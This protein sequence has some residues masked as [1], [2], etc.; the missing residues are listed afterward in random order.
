M[1]IEAAKVVRRLVDGSRVSAMSPRLPVDYVQTY[2]ASDGTP[3]TV[4][5]AMVFDTYESGLAWLAGY[6]LGDALEVW[7]CTCASASRPEVGYRLS[8]LNEI[9]AGVRK[10]YEAAEMLALLTG[11]ASR[12]WPDV[13]A[14]WKDMPSGRELVVETIGYRSYDATMELPPGTLVATDVVLAERL[15]TFGG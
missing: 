2:F 8:G 15:A 4:P 10:P 3:L 9:R 11:R 13:R 6:D 12:V 7:N 1:R 14:L 5:V